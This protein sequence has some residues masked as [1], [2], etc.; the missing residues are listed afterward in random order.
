VSDAIAFARIL[1]RLARV[2]S[3]L[4]TGPLS[5]EESSFT[6]PQGHAVMEWL[7]ALLRYAFSGESRRRFTA[8]GLLFWQPITARP[9]DFVLVG[10]TPKSSHDLGNLAPRWVEGPKTPVQVGPS[11]A[12][13]PRSRPGVGRYFCLAEGNLSSIAMDTLLRPHARL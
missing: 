13:R 12:T 5:P 6:C 3:V 4:G 10:H 1:A 2:F 9:G 11:G 7:K 8:S